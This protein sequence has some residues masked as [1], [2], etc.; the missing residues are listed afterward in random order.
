MPHNRLTWRV[1]LT[2][3]VLGAMAAP[4][5]TTP[6]PTSTLPADPIAAG[7]LEW[8]EVETLRQQFLDTRLAQVERIEAIRAAI[9]R[10]RGIIDRY[11]SHPD[12][13]DWRLSLGQDLIFRL[14]QPYHR[15]LLC[16]PTDAEAAEGLSPLAEEA[17]TVLADVHETV[18]RRIEAI[19][20]LPAEAFRKAVASGQPRRLVGMKSR[21]GY[22]LAWG[23]FYWAVSLPDTEPVQREQ[24]L[25][26]VVTYLAPEGGRL[27][28][29]LGRPPMRLAG[30]LLLGMSQRRLDRLDAARRSLH[31]AL[32]ICSRLDGTPEEHDCFWEQLLVRLEYVRLL[33]DQGQPDAAAQQLEALRRWLEH[34]PHERPDRLLAEGLLLPGPPGS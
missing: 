16:D 4:A 9:Q 18:V 8:R 7:H 34:Y 15:R 31:K 20:R 23:R 28:G 30:L 25:V 14:G 10:A 1:L 17:S 13:L 32:A 24:R 21:A 2:G 22:A 27:R 33:C 5:A 19:S 29:E 3:L 12:R 6:S 11:P 26:Q